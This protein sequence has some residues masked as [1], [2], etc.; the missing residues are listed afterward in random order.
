[1][2]SGDA[3]HRKLQQSNREHLPPEL[4][5]IDPSNLPSP[6]CSLTCCEVKTP[7][8][9]EQLCEVKIPSIL[10]SPGTT[11]PVSEAGEAANRSS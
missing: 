9:T 8:F 10:P 3:P 2:E 6:A 5:Y 11:A 4:H 1:M 7:P